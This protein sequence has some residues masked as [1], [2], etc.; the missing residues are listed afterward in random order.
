MQLPDKSIASLVKYYY[1]WKKTRTRTSLM[2][3]QARKLTSGGKEGENGS[4]N[5]S[6]LGSNTDSE[7]EE[8]VRI[9]KIIESMHVLRL[10]TRMFFLL[11]LFFFLQFNSKII[12]F[13]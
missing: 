12:L 8:K 2:D 1:S 7:S 4:E 3:R 5:G 6:E 9:L 13:L 10:F 11:F